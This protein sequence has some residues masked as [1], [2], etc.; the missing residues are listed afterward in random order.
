MDHPYSCPYKQLGLVIV[1]EEHRKFLQAK[2]IGTRYNSVV[3]P[4]AM[5]WKDEGQNIVGFCSTF[6]LKVIR[7]P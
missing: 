7:M 1:D 2:R 6:F 3:I 5:S 4:L